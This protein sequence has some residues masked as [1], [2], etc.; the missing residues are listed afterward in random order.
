MNFVKRPAGTIIITTSSHLF[1]LN[2]SINC[3]YL[4]ACTFFEEKRFGLIVPNMLAYGT[5]KPLDIAA[6]SPSLGARDIIDI[7]DHEEMQK[8]IFIGH[9]W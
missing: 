8:A 1:R 3:V 2:P 9:D 6:Y 4:P 5:S 7:L